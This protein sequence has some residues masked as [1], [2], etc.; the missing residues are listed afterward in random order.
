MMSIPPV[1]RLSQALYNDVPSPAQSRSGGQRASPGRTASLAA[2]ASIGATETNSRPAGMV[3]LLL[4]R[5]FAVADHS[6]HESL[7]TAGGGAV[8]ERAAEH[9]VR[10]DAVVTK[11]Q[12][13]LVRIETTVGP[14]DERDGSGGN[15]SCGTASS[16]VTNNGICTSS[17]QPACSMQSSA[18]V[19]PGGAALVVVESVLGFSAV[20]SLLDRSYAENM[21]LSANPSTAGSAIEPEQPPGDEPPR[22]CAGTTGPAD[23][24]S[25]RDVD[26]DGNKSFGVTR[27]STSNSSNSSTCGVSAAVGRLV[28]WLRIAAAITGLQERGRPGGFNSSGSVLGGSTSACASSVVETAMNARRTDRTATGFSM[29]GLDVEDDLLLAAAVA[30][31]GGR[32]HGTWYKVTG[33]C[34]R[35]ERWIAFDLEPTAGPPGQ[36]ERRTPEGG[37]S[38]NG[39][40]G[41][42]LQVRLICHP[43]VTMVPDIRWC[44]QLISQA[45]AIATLL[46]ANAKLSTLGGGYFLTRQVGQ[47]IRLA[48]AQSEVAEA[49]GDLRL[50]GKCRVNVAYN[51]IWLG[52]YDEAQRIINA[53]V[54]ASRAIQDE[55]LENM[56]SIA[57]R[58]LKR[59]RRANHR[60]L[61][62][63]LD[64]PS[65]GGSSGDE[66]AKNGVSQGWVRQKIDVRTD[67]WHRVRAL[68]MY[69]SSG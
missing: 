45:K 54:A 6:Y 47:A 17:Q 20:Q 50:A 36:L 9:F 65:G 60:L 31:A 49:L 63:Q 59:S 64:A 41:E 14:Q 16:P 51:Y 29:C 23:V 18:T 68:P 21:R 39:A 24:C 55:E 8:R 34:D 26:A 42:V 56:A 52:Q 5:T 11:V 19:A 22:G 69:Y 25:R 53:Q 58:F 35:G 57:G 37:D 32:A 33:R 44:L 4:P 3:R 1:V 30:T 28:A 46:N 43:L 62:S 12:Q 40:A 2:A 38:G 13:N 27:C 7:L 15:S 61:Q 48:L 10:G 66:G 67:E